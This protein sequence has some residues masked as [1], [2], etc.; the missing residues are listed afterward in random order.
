MPASPDADNPLIPP[1]DTS[2]PTPTSPFT[3]PFSLPTISPSPP[4]S[5]PSDID[6]SNTTY[7]TLL[8][9]LAVILLGFVYYHTRQCWK[10]RWA[11]D[12]DEPPTYVSS[13]YGTNRPRVN[14]HL[15]ANGGPVLGGRSTA[16]RVSTG[17]GTAA[18]THQAA[19][20]GPSAVGVSAA[21]GET[22]AVA[23]AADP[24][25]GNLDAA[26]GGLP[27]GV[28]SDSNARG[29]VRRER[30]ATHIKQLPERGLASVTVHDLSTK[31]CGPECADTINR[32]LPTVVLP[33]KER[34]RSR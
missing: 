17:A 28:G 19:C 22:A 30:H 9:I 4:T 25:T 24:A 5:P 15:A 31:P 7:L 6:C 16:T 33:K 14:V 29:A 3:P 11:D 12:S 2:T 8:I 1:P 20:T 10:A 23:N 13:I 34:T 32:R 21:T 26:A 18:V 27:I